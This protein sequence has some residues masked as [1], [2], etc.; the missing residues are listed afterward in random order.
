MNKITTLPALQSLLDSTVI[1]AV[2]VFLIAL[3]IAYIISQMIPYKGGIDKSYITRRIAFI[4]VGLAS[5]IGFYLYNDLVVKDVIM[6]AGFK[7]M[8]A[9]RN[10][11]CLGVTVFGYFF[12]GIMLMLVFRKSKFG[13]ILGKGKE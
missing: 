5:C 12:V 1:Y 10:N 13:S 4:F 7:N 11:L 6:N 8:F 3:L 2:I 9:D